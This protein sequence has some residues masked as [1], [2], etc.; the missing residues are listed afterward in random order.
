MNSYIKVNVQTDKEKLFLFDTHKS[1]LSY[2]TNYILFDS[3]DEVIVVADQGDFNITTL[4]AVKYSINNKNDILISLP[5][6]RFNELYDKYTDQFFKLL[7]SKDPSYEAKIFSYTQML[8]GKGKINPCT[9]NIEK[10]V[11]E[12]RPKLGDPHFKRNY[13][14]NVI[15]M[16]TD[17]SYTNVPKII[18]V[19]L[20]ESLPQKIG[21]N[22]GVEFEDG[23]FPKMNFNP[24]F[25]IMECANEGR[26]VNFEGL[27]KLIANF[28]NDDCKF[29]IH[30]SWPYFKGLQ[31]FLFNLRNY[32][33]SVGVFFYSKSLCKIIA[34]KQNIPV[35]D[36]LKEF[37]IEGSRLINYQ[38]KTNFKIAVPFYDIIDKLEIKDLCAMEGDIDQLITSIENEADNLKNEEFWIKS[39]LLFPPMVDTFS[40]PSELKIRYNHEDFGFIYLPITEYVKR[41]LPD[42]LIISGKFNTL[43]KEL[44]RSHDLFLKLRGQ[45]SYS[46]FGKRSLMQV[47]ILNIIKDAMDNCI[48]HSKIFLTALHPIS[49]TRRST[50][51]FIVY[52]INVLD[53][54]FTTIPYIHID[55]NSKEL[56]L[57]NIKY[58]IKN[59]EDG[60][61]ILFENLCQYFN[62][63]GHLGDKFL[64]EMDGRN[65]ISLKIHIDDIDY[66]EYIYSDNNSW[67]RKALNFIEL[68]L[69]RIRLDIDRKINIDYI[70]SIEQKSKNKLT[71]TKKTILIYPKQNLNII[72]HKIDIEILSVDFDKL[73]NIPEVDRKISNVLIPGPIPFFSIGENIRVSR[74]FDCLLMPFKSVTF[75][76]YPGSN[77]S[78]LV[79]QIE[80]VQMLL[81]DEINEINSIDLNLSAEI[82]NRLPPRFDWG[83]VST[84]VPKAI[85][86]DTPID[87]VIRDSPQ[88]ESKLI[89]LKE[90]FEKIIE[91]ER[92]KYEDVKSDLT[93]R[94]RITLDC[95][96]EDGDRSAIQFVKGTIV[97]VQSNDGLIIKRIENLQIGDQFL[98]LK[99]DYLGIDEYV[100]RGFADCQD[101]SIEKVYSP[102]EVLSTFI[103]A[104]TS[105]RNGDIYCDQFSK[106]YWLTDEQKYEFF[107]LLQIL[108]GSNEY[109]K[110]FEVIIQNNFWSDWLD[111]EEIENLFITKSKIDKK[112]LYSISK[113][114]GMTLAESTFKQYSNIG[115]KREKKYFFNEHTNTE[116][117]GKLTGNNM[118]I[119]EAEDI[120]EMGKKLTPILITIGHAISRVIS[121]NYNP[122]NELDNLLKDQ[123]V[124]CR[125]I[126]YR[127]TQN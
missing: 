60:N 102:F 73:V 14:K 97:R 124:K 28:V 18:F 23:N 62:D 80:N 96:L 117:I 88:V 4:L 94:E 27:E 25:L 47:Q 9:G 95:E 8:W 89:T 31:R 2:L 116:S 87:V 61:K 13:S 127:R 42:N 12:S 104:T 44:E 57:G 64:I 126:S 35:D 49:G 78:K 3:D 51:K 110:Y 120:N 91:N 34:K 5:A 10:F 53:D 63:L 72:T 38:G 65:E 15:S 81:S 54:L 26:R 20:E 37:T 99:N 75:F 115:K 29:V 45:S 17:G 90:I 68:I 19:S 105:I 114:L 21:E 24:K 36:K 85:V 7:I 55:K 101:I 71:I 77:I 1:S 109:D 69:F 56:S 50:L 119:E 74:G 112:L 22:L 113:K 121:G 79:K 43:A 86:D 111:Y 108:L 106:F 70:S 76:A 84:V 125:L 40:K 52:L 41:K 46:H 33:N 58:K 93:F 67:N 39:I 92:Q 48:P 11:V 6:H 30:F 32:S 66:T 123:L 100:I 118:L 82:N 107:V 16:I 122:Y 59:E 83:V 103:E 98:Y